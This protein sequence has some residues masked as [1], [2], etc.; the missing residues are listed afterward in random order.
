MNSG[1]ENP[2]SNYGGIVS[3][4][5]FIGREKDLDILRRRVISPREPGN[6]V[7]IG[8]PRIGKSSLVYHGLMGCK[9]DLLERRI[10]PVWLN[11]AMYEESSALFRALVA[12]CLDEIEQKDWLSSAIQRS[13]TKALVASESWAD[14]FKRATRFFEAV[15]ADGI[16]V[17]FVLDEFDYARKLFRGDASRF[18]ALRELSYRPE[19]RVT[20]VV[21]SRRTV[22]EIETQTQAISTFDGIFMKH[23][24]SMFSEPDVEE[25]YNRCSQ[26]GLG[27]DQASRDRVRFYCGGHPFLLNVVGYELVELSRDQQPLDVDRA[28]HRAMDSIVSEYDRIVGLLLDDCRLGRLLQILYGPVIDAVQ[29]DADEFARYGIIEEVEGRYQAFSEHF[30]AYLSLISREL[31]A[32]LWPVWRETETLLRELINVQL[33]ARHSEHWLPAISKAH[34]SLAGILD[35]CS[36]AQRREAGLFGDRASNSLLDYA[37][38]QD[39]FAIIFAEWGLFQSILG[40]DRSYW[41]QRASLLAKIRNPLA[42]NRLAVLQDYERKTAE[43]Y[44]QEIS[45]LIRTALR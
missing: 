32:D 33:T 39:L 9:Q 41:G 31:S 18:Q 11:L 7:I 16:R 22:R 19:W 36:E 45:S 28:A 3:G 42:H 15:R 37:Y 14:H 40:K 30:G 23:Y 21:V 20:Y 24:L 2:F 34:K 29:A 38:P 8:E 13:A 17:I 26:A 10:V 35:R 44:C 1:F 25:Y 4:D 12:D 6:L 5:R 43:G 27:L